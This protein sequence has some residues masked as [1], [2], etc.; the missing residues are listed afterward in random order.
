MRTIVPLVLGLGAGF[1]AMLYGW[2]RA[3]Q[4]G[5]ADEQTQRA[6]VEVPA[7]LFVPVRDAA[8]IAST[9]R[10]RSCAA[11]DELSVSFDS[12]DREQMLHVAAL[13][14]ARVA[15]LDERAAERAATHA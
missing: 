14:L 6:G 5:R 11:G 2:G 9:P 15:Y 8:K 1:A 3:Y 4:T 12:D 13:Y 7:R 10:S